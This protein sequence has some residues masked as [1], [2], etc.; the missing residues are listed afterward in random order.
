MVATM[1]TFHTEKCHYMASK[2]EASVHA[3]LCSS[4]CQFVICSM[5]VLANLT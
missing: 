4:V 2:H 1:T 3:H 5:F